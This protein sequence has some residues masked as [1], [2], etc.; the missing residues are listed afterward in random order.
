MNAV[1]N[2]CCTWG[3]HGVCHLLAP[4]EEADTTQDTQPDPEQ[5]AP[6]L[7]HVTGCKVAHPPLHLLIPPLYCLASTC[8][9]GVVLGTNCISGE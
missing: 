4:K 9:V 1:C 6:L 7:S 3:E 2:L 5:R 8:S